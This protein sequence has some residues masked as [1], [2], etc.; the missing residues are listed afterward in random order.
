MWS[1]IT[2]QI[3]RLVLC[4]HIMSAVPLLLVTGQNTGYIL[5]KYARFAFLNVFLLLHVMLC[6]HCMLAYS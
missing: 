4:N 3:S 5:E 1:L 2:Q 6:C